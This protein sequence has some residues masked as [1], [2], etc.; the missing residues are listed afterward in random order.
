LLLARSE[1]RS[2]RGRESEKKEKRKCERRE[3]RKNKS[4]C[5][6]MRK[7]TNCEVSICCK[8]IL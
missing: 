7:G 6:R 3:E 4:E 2:E 1:K 5:E 8:H